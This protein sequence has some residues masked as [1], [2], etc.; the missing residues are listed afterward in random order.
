MELIFSY[1]NNIV[2]NILGLFFLMILDSLLIYS[3]VNHDGFT[4]IVGLF[5]LCFL[6]LSTLI[7]IDSVIQVILKTNTIFVNNNELL[8]PPYFFL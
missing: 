7:L 2:K 3:L 6:M 8:L 4:L 1:N 5:L